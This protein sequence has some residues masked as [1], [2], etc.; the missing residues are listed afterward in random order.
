[1]KYFNVLGIVLTLLFILTG[2]FG[3]T[4]DFTPPEI[5][6][7]SSNQNKL[8]EAN[9]KWRGEGNEPIINEVNDIVTL[10]KEQQ[11]M[12]FNA[13]ERVDILSDHADFK[14]KGLYVTL[15]QDENKIDLEVSDTSFHLPKE[16]GEYVIEVNL[17]TDRGNAQYVGNLII[18]GR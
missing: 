4:Y 7:S 16:I 3:E 18:D 10:A 12:H 17:E 15:W 6:L 5:S 1:M 14:T 2:C 13:G 8:V 9:I 11:P